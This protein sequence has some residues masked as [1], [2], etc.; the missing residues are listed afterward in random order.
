M[1]L[2]RL[3]YCPVFTEIATGR[4]FYCDLME[5]LLRPDAIKVAS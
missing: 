1:Y 2:L 4:N 5:L 3:F